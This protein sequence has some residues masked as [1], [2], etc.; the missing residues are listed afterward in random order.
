[1]IQKDYYEMKN[2]SENEFQFAK[3]Y[4]YIDQI[5]VK[6]EY[7]NQ[8][9]ARKLLSK[10]ID[11][12]KDLNIDEVQLDHWNKNEEDSKFF[13]ASGFNYFN[14]KMKIRLNSNKA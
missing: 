13:T 8:G 2:R 10:V 11:I 3:T 14:K 7:R 9:I 1:M 6:E 4:I 12:A 5:S